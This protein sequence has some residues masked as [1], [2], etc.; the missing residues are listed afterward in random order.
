MCQQLQSTPMAIHRCGLTHTYTFARLQGLNGP[1]E[2]LA[3]GCLPLTTNLTACWLL[4]PGK[5]IDWLL[6]GCH[7]SIELM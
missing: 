4:Q 6:T 7:A 1:L 2:S 3:Y 5:G